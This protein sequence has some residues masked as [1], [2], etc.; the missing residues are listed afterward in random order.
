[1]IDDFTIHIIDIDFWVSMHGIV[2]VGMWGGLLAVRTTSGMHI[3]QNREKRLHT[4]FFGGFFDFCGIGI[5][6][7]Q[8]VGKFLPFLH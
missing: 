7:C 2:V 8:S 4:G 6:H 5:P 3:P 1:M